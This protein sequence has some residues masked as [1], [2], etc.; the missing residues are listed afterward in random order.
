VEL[1]CVLSLLRV[2]G[3]SRMRGLGIQLAG[4]K[5]SMVRP[6]LGVAFIL[7]PPLPT[8]EPLHRKDGVVSRD[9]CCAAPRWAAHFVL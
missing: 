5:G 4:V 8:R 7:V 9:S 1:A 6:E 3:Y 2:V